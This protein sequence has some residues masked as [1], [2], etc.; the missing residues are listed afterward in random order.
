VTQPYRTLGQIAYEA[1]A[2]DGEHAPWPELTDV[3]R[4]PWFDAAHAVATEIATVYHRRE[5]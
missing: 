5:D 4:K 2:G 3:Q 1:F